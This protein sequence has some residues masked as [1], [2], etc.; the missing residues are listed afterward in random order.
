MQLRDH[1]AVVGKNDLFRVNPR[2]LTVEPGFNLR[3]LETPSAREKLD[4]LKESI[5]AVGVLSPV[6]IRI[7]GETIYLTD[8]HRRH[9]AVMELIDEGAEIDTVPAVAEPKAVNEA[10]RVA[11]IIDF[12]SGKPL[13]ALEKAEGIRRLMGYGWDRTKI[14]QRLGV[15]TQ[16]VATWEEM[17]ALPEAVKDAVR[18]EV[19]SVTAARQVVREQGPTR[20]T[21]TIAAARE[22]ARSAGRTKVMPRALGPTRK[23]QPI[24]RNLIDV[25]VEALREIAVRG[26]GPQDRR[27]ARL[28]LKY[29]GIDCQP[30]EEPLPDTEIEP[31]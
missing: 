4:T 1:D 17:L 27:S 19:V 18:E 15:S 23:P 20:A 16:T 30:E 31:V 2:L 21:E 9:K 7:D 6:T 13:T 11:R 28:C 3:D 5:R 26:D 24:N 14:A 12:G 8:G 10:E 22:T 25:L 29:Q